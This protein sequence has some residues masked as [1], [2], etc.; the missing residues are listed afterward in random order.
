VIVF[1]LSS[2]AAGLAQGGDVL[3]AARAVQGIGAAA[4]MPASLAIVMDAFDP[5]EQGRAVGLRSGVSSVFLTLGPVVGGLPTQGV[6]WRAIFWVN[7]PVSVVTLA[8]TW[9]ADPQSDRARA[10]VARLER[11]GVLLLVPGLAAT[12]IAL[13]EAAK[14]GWGSQPWTAPRRRR[15]RQCRC[16]SRRGRARSTGS[17]RS[18][19]S[20]PW[21]G[22][23]WRSPG[24][25]SCVGGGNSCDT[26]APMATY[27]VNERGVAKARELIAARQ[28]VLD[29]QWGDVQPAAAQQN[30]YLERH[31]WDEYAGWFLGLTEGAA[32]QTKARYAFVY[33]DLRRLHRSGLIA[34]HYRAAEWRHKAIELA[35]HELLQ[36]LDRQAGIA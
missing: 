19:R 9:V 16:G 3:I 11:V 1:A 30:D 2:A 20:P 33:G 23:R 17:P 34:C 7:L 36:E 31:S 22:R 35:A 4:M 12:V 8:L 29:S 21:P 5:G 28:Y 14:W 15:P 26:A 10:G 25:R 32:E 13:M 27:T 24:P 18:S 6:N